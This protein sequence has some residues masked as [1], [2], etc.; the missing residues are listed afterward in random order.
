MMDKY[1]SYTQG[2]FFWNNY[3]LRVM[4]VIYLRGVEMSKYMGVY[5]LKNKEIVGINDYIIFNFDNNKS[6]VTRIIWQN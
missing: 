1:R 6:Q 2:E 3:S 5:I 4:Y